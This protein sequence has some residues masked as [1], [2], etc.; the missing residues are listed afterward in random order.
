MSKQ[1]NLFKRKE[2][3]QATTW[4]ADENIPDQLVPL[5]E[6]D[7]LGTHQIENED[8]VF[9]LE[10][11][12]G[13]RAPMWPYPVEKRNEIR[14]AYLKLK[15]YQPEMKK[16]PYSGPEGHRRSFQSS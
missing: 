16:F 6:R 9:S 15:P 7:T 11:E 13:L 8:L 5:H 3:E 14:R 2:P 12:P 10:R 4:I 1:T